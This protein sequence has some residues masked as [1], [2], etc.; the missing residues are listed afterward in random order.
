MAKIRW[1]DLVASLTKLTEQQI[2]DLLDEEVAKH[3]RPVV[4]RRLQGLARTLAGHLS[5]RPLTALALTG[6]VLA[7]HLFLLTDGF[8]V[9]WSDKARLR[10]CGLR[11]CRCPSI[12][13]SAM[14]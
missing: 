14:L 1:L 10:I 7:L 3:K 13:G 6:L 9:W 8:P 4:A 2:S 5:S 12:A 11:A